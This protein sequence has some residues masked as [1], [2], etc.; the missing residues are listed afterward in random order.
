MTKAIIY[1]RFSPRRNSEESES[2]EVQRA[3]CEKFA[4]KNG[5]EIAATFDDP[6][7]S[8]SDEF[9]EKLWSAIDALPKGGVLLVYKR[10]RLARNVYL[11]EHIN[12]CVARKGATIRAVTGDVDGD[13][14]EAVLARQITAAIA[15]YERKCIAARTRHAMRYHMSNGRRMGAEC[16]YGWQPDPT[17]PKRMLPCQREREAI[18]MI[19]ERHREGMAYNAIMTWLNAEH[20]DLARH[21]RWNTKTVRKICMQQT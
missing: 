14:P 21:G 17:D 18:E 11:A 20:A 9:R 6:D 4:A 16:P 13:T 7:V 15:E 12:R 3:Y 1:T 2:C 8:G 10:D 19:L 5:M